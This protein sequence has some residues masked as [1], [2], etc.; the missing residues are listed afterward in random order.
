MQPF[1]SVV[2]HYGGIGSEFRVEQTKLLQGS[3]G[4]IAEELLLE[5]VWKVDESRRHEQVWYPQLCELFVEKRPQSGMLLK[6]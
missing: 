3:S 2:A 4:A 6:R 5:L 1:R